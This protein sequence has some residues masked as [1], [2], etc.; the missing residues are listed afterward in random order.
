MDTRQIS[1]PGQA[2]VA[3]GPHDQTGMYVMHHAFR[4]DLAAFESAVRNTPL[5]EDATWQA[6]QRRWA[7][8]GEVLHH[9]H[10]IEDVAFWPVLVRHAESAADTDALAMLQAM[11]D[12]HE[13]IDP[14]LGAVTAGFASMVEHPCADHRNALDVHVTATR[15]ALLEHLVHEESDALPFLQ[16]VMT[17]EEYAACEKAAQ[18][19]YPLKLVPFLVAWA[20]DGVPDDVATR[21]LTEAGAAYRLALKVF[22]PGF[23]RGERRAFKYAG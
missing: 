22:R 21:F 11:E 17:T 15:A 14:G 12:E 20:F 3:D 9:H 4:R 1:L 6:L 19:G 10:G 23:V 7:R 5:H 16:Q 2:H 13:Q 8:F 18:E